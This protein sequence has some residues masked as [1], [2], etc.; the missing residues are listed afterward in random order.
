MAKGS[1]RRRRRVRNSPEGGEPCD[2][3]DAV[4]RIEGAAEEAGDH[5]PVA[6]LVNLMTAAQD[7][8]EHA[9]LRHLL[10]ICPICRRQFENLKVKSRELRHWNLGAVLREAEEAPGLWKQMAAQP[11]PQ[12]LAAVRSEPGYQTWG[13]SLLL[14]R[15]SDSSA[16]SEPK[17]AA[18]L[19][20]LGL[21]VADSLGPAYDQDWIEDLAA[22]ACACLGNARR[23]LGELAAANDAFDEA[24]RRW[25]G[26]T[27]SPSVEAEILAREALLRRDEHGLEEAIGLLG[28]VYEI[29]TEE[30]ETEQ[31]A[32]DPR[33]AGAARVH[34][35]WCHYHLGRT[36]E[37]LARLNQAERL[38]DAD[39]DA[40]LLLVL[41][42]GEV[43]SFLRL[44]RLE[45]AARALADAYQRAKGLGVT[46]VRLRLRMAEARMIESS[47][48]ERKLWA[49]ARGFLRLARGVDAALA[50]LE[51]AA[52]YVRENTLEE[53]PR[54]ASELFPVWSSAEIGR[55]ENAALLV[56]QNA[57]S[58]R[59]VTTDL[60]RNLASLLERERR[61]SCD[62]WSA[63]GTVL[64]RTKLG[65]AD[66]MPGNP[67]GWKDG[68]E[69]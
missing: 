53:L 46:A 17:R 27:E 58:E 25:A 20:N 11:Y 67:D 37:A 6:V 28:R 54:L 50:F 31:E 61:P 22:L 36:E 19:A 40:G 3:A 33:L 30:D 12:Q 18:Q 47:R 21:A 43:R 7:S 55:V 4:A 41:R 13:F 68:G 56:F 8:D 15:R 9:A 24:R 65:I 60:V 63:W 64:G 49:V 34:E 45:E 52:L 51:L 29:H 38:L 26:G 1:E 59:R 69:K 16:A 14:L 2:G 10:S 44:G 32:Y 5:L 42:Y 57:C 39:R 62:W 23:E 48:A 66:S 35:A